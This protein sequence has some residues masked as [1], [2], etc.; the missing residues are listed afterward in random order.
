MKNMKLRRVSYSPGD[1]DMLGEYHSVSLEKG[2]DGKWTFV[3]R[4]RSIHSEPT[5]VCAYEVSDEDVSRFEEFILK[6][7]VVSLENRPKSDMFATDYSPWRWSLDYE[8][9]S[10]GKTERRYCGID[11]YKRYSA[12]DYKLLNELSER[13]YALRGEKLSEKTED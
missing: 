4:D 12:G 9:T 8:R 5:V 11:E 10:F 7:K 2:G 6:N 3:C 13:L 1:C